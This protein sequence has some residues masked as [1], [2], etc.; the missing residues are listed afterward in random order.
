MMKGRVD[1]KRTRGRMKNGMIDDLRD[2][3]LYEILKRK[4]QE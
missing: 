2:E 1:G 3:N 4:A